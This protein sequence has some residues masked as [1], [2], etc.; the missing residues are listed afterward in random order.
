MPKRIKSE[1]EEATTGHGW[2]S[3]S[4]RYDNCNETH[5]IF[6]IPG[7]HDIFMFLKTDF[8]KNGGEKLAFIL[9]FL[10]ELYHW[11]TK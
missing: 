11:I 7:I 8:K 1:L 4:F 6:L 10:Y 9:T 2:D 3:L 5:Q